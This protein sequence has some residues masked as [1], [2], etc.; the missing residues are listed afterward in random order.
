MKYKHFIFDMD[1]TLTESRSVMTNA[2]AAGL[3]LITMNGG[4]IT[5]IS[6][7]DKEQ[8]I[9][10]IGGGG[11]D[12]F[13]I[14]AQ[15][16]NSTPYWS[17]ELTKEQK[18]RILHHIAM[19]RTDYNYLFMKCDEEDLVED[20]GCQISFSFTGHHADLGVKKAFDTDGSRRNRYLESRPF[21]D[22]ELVAK[23]GGMTCIDYI[24]KEGT[25][26]KNIE[27]LM[28]LKHWKPEDCVYIGDALF[29]GGNDESVIGVIPKLIRVNNP[30]ETLLAIN[31]LIND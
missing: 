30:D 3:G 19:L 11:D 1:G 8:M 14:M 26:G 9:K 25:K 15:N 5:I 21:E 4:D 12:E 10:Q 28:A 29:K 2:M 7:A 13:T 24:N 22:K 16:G 17:N 20:R 31:A 27:R 6:G 23:I 18:E